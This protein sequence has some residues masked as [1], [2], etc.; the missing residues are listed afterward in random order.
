[1][2][3]ARTRM[4]LQGGY[5]GLV[6]DGGFDT[7][8]N[9]LGWTLSPSGRGNQWH[10]NAGMFIPVGSSVMIGPNILVNRPLIGP[11]TPLEDAV[12]LEN[13]WY[14]PGAGARNFRDDPF[15]VLE[16]RETYG[17]E[18]L[19]IYDPTPGSYF[20]SWDNL[21]RENAPFAAS[22][23]LAFRRLPTVRDAQFSFTADGT[24]FAFPGSPPAAD[25]W[26]IT[27]R[28]M[29][30][31]NGTRWVLAPYVA[32]EQ[33]RGIDDRLITRAG[34]DLTAARG[35]L[36]VQGFARF[37]DWGPFDF[38]RDFNFTF[39]YQT[40]LDVSTGVGRAQFLNMSTR[41]GVRAKVRGLNE[42]SVVSSPF[43]QA[44]P[45]TIDSATGETF[46][47]IEPGAWEGELFTYLRVMR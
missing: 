43:D 38:Y 31:T 41:L 26:T 17:G 33:S 20:F 4:F 36:L 16:N 42:F 35:R 5:Q 46:S 32:Q 18:L 8:R 44:P 14:F 47:N 39:P 37:N 13:Q 9:Q 10:V 2:P 25:V 30:N 12:D 21:D 3:L 27:S 1:R 23:D 40:M 24:L 11:N 19:F 15:A 7:R 29:L 45:L 34:V 6:A 22:L 28:I